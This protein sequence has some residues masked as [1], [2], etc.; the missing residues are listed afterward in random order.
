M[1]RD[2][3]DLWKN[4]GLEITGRAPM[5]A[6][7]SVTWF[8]MAFAALSLALAQQASGAAS[9]PPL[10]EVQAAAEVRPVADRGGSHADADARACLEFV[11]NLGVIRCAE[12]YRAA[13]AADTGRPGKHQLRKGSAG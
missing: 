8:L 6:A 4:A 1:A 12:K 13:R 5:A 3:G 10:A 9:E 2:A 7:H 11:T